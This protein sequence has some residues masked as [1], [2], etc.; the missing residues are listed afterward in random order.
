MTLASTR[1]SDAPL[2]LQVGAFG[3]PVNAERLRARLTDRLGNPV[4][5]ENSVADG[6]T[7][8]KVRIGPL[9]SRNEASELRARLAALGLSTPHLVQ[10]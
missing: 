2:F 9:A 1:A 10:N 7:L 4:R 5:I 8:Y 3:N 6:L